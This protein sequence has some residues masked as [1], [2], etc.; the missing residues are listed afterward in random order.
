MGAARNI[1]YRLVTI[2][3]EAPHPD[4]QSCNISLVPR[5]P[6][7]LSVACSTGKAEGKPG[8]KVVTHIIIEMCSFLTYVHTIMK[9]GSVLLVPI[10][11]IKVANPSFN[12]SPSHHA[13]VTRF[14]NHY[15]EKKVVSLPSFMDRVTSNELGILFSFL[16]SRPV[17][18]VPSWSSKT[19]QLIL[20]RFCSPTNQPELTLRPRM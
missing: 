13:I 3:C 6:F 15:R 7:Q 16:S 19:P 20:I 11:S 9:P 10:Y 12:H 1:E 18:I 5:L 8:N 14:P 17:A 4:C 2:N